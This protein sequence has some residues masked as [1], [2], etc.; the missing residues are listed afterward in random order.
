MLYIVLH[1]RYMDFFTPEMTHASL[2][3]CPKIGDWLIDRLRKDDPNVKLKVLTVIKVCSMS[4]TGQH[5]L[6]RKYSPGEI[7]AAKYT[8]ALL[9]KCCSGPRL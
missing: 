6:Y 3:A 2:D 5:R 1:L 8:T 9:Y 7:E 4:L